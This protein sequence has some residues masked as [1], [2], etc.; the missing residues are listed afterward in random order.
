MIVIAGFRLV[1]SVGNEE[2][3][4]KVKKQLMYA[5]IGLVVAIMAYAIVNFVVASFV[6]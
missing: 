3:Q 6:K 2:V 1:I 4:Q 5:I